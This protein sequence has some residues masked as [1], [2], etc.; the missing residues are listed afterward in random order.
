MMNLEG[1]HSG[2]SR[3]IHLSQCVFSGRSSSRGKSQQAL[4]ILTTLQKTGLEA[5]G[6]LLPPSAGC[7]EVLLQVKKKSCARRKSEGTKTWLR[8]LGLLRDRESR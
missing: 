5:N 6:R 3:G 4:G 8:L 1:N 7:F 2:P